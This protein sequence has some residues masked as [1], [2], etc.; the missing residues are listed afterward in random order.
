MIRRVV[1]KHFPLAT[2][3]EVQK[4]ISMSGKTDLKTLDKWLE[5]YIY[6]TIEECYDRYDDLLTTTYDDWVDNFQPHQ[7]VEQLAEEQKIPLH[8]IS[9][10]AFLLKVEK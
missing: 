1:K 8:Y 10:N 3:Q 6:I 9:E 7:V 4:I 2:P 5:D